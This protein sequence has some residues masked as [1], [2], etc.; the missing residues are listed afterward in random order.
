M[1]KKVIRLI[2]DIMDW[3][4]NRITGVDPTKSTTSNLD[5]LTKRLVGAE[6]EAQSKAEIYMSTGLGYVGQSLAG[7]VSILRQGLIKIGD[8]PALRDSRFTAGR[9]VADWANI[10]GNNQ[11][12]HFYELTGELFNRLDSG[13]QGLVGELVN[14]VKG[15]TKDTAKVHAL[16]R[17]GNFILDK[18]RKDTIAAMAKTLSDRY[19]GTLTKVEKVAVTKFL[20]RTD[21]VALI[22]H[23][24]T[25]VQLTNLIA[26]I[27]YLN[28]E[29]NKFESDIR[30]AVPT[31]YATHYLNQAETL[32]FNMVNGFSRSL[33]AVPNAYG[34]ARLWGIKTVDV[35]D[36]STIHTVE[37]LIDA[38][39]TLRAI[40]YTIANQNDTASIVGLMRRETSRTDLGNS[41]DSNGLTF[42][43]LQ[44]QQ[45]KDKALKDNFGGDPAL[46]RKGYM[47]DITNPY[48]DVQVAPEA[49]QQEM[50][51]R[52]YALQAVLAKDPTDPT[53]VSMAM[54][55]ANGGGLM[56]YMRGA[57]AITNNKTK[58]KAVT[59]F[60][61]VAVMAS[62][63]AKNEAA[64][65]SIRSSPAH[66]N[67]NPVYMQAVFTPEGKI[68]SYRSIMAEATK[69]NLLER[70][71][72]FS[73]VL[74]K[75]AG[76][77]YDKTVTKPHNQTV[78]DALKEQYDVDKAAGKLDNYI[79]V[80]ANSTDPELRQMWAMMPYATQ[81]H[82]KKVFGGTSVPIRAEFLRVIFGN[83]K[84]TIGSLWEE[85]GINNNLFQQTLKNMFDVFTAGNGLFVA[86][87]S[88]RIWQEIVRTA[89]Q[90]IVVRT[91]SV[92]MMN[93]LSNTYQLAL[94]G[95]GMREA[96]TGQYTGYKKA[97][98][99]VRNSSRINELKLLMQDTS[100]ATSTLKMQSELNQLKHLQSINEV[101]ELIEAGLL[102]TIVLDVNQ[103]VDPFS[104][105]SQLGDKFDEQLDRLPGGAKDAAKF[106]LMTRD[107]ESYEF[108]NRL[109]QFGDFSARYVMYKKLTTRAVNPMNKAD[110]INAVITEFINYDLPT[111]RALQYGNDMGII[112][113]SRYW[114]RIQKV[115][116]KNFAENPGR[117]LTGL[118]L[119]TMLGID[120]PDG[121]DSAIL[122]TGLLH[123]IGGVD[124]V[125]SGLM[126]NPILPNL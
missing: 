108:M 111:H 122:N 52:G 60:V 10:V 45:L 70:N 67:N 15:T 77:V 43:L 50:K 55:I 13:K 23:G 71:D 47:P 24:Y 7:A 105:G 68:S 65:F 79:R 69:D 100:N 61:D 113:F 17:V 106:L 18:G 22:K 119:Q 85:G 99:Y 95:V 40:E 38:L 66:I 64:L 110:A 56:T 73:E 9:L 123:S 27:G 33:H 41:V 94:N 46:M 54:Y 21:T 30:A 92:T 116:M 125:V 114:L 91:G 35:P 83:R 8:I 84:V 115:I 29:I 63:R 58:G 103:D 90:N 14:E 121:G 118:A 37:P 26:D 42:T 59:D 5:K 96:L 87:K 117:V 101:G 28:Q 16:S 12:H 124:R 81:Q 98:E 19:K 57:L 89:K 72:D 6:L 1:F 48:L 76:N 82:V 62:E 86:T 25:A 31:N 88:E 109:V 34:I 49:E 97:V 11:T 107:S 78:I 3:L 75:L 80:E 120:V 53:T 104:Y 112:W 36:V 74:G 93:L 44:H 51:Q 20:L 32:G 126:S 39:A 102:Q 2:G 4:S